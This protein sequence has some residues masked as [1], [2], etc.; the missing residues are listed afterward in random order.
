MVRPLACIVCL[1]AWLASALF[2]CSGLAV[3]FRGHRRHSE[4]RYIITAAAHEGGGC[5]DWVY[6]GVGLGPMRNSLGSLL[7]R[8]GS[9][10]RD[11]RAGRRYLAPFFRGG[12]GHSWHLA[13]PPHP[14]GDSRSRVGGPTIGPSRRRDARGGR[15]G[16]PGA[17][18]APRSVVRSYEF[19]RTIPRPPVPSVGSGPPSSSAPALRLRPAPR[20]AVEPSR[21]SSARPC[22]RADRIVVGERWMSG[23]RAAAH[24]PVR[25]RFGSCGTAAPSRLL[26]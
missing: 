2:D 23:Q 10:R 9:A 24:I 8:L 13:P 15:A 11:P 7:V 19:V 16:A 17:G 22:V 3:S 25:R 26:P 4:D 6:W 21:A 20:R 1:R 5:W 18:S 14:R 12:A